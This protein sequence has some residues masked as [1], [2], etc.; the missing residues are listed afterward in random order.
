MQRFVVFCCLNMFIHWHLNSREP[1]GISCLRSPDVLQQLHSCICAVEN[2][3]VLKH[4]C[5]LFVSRYRVCARTSSPP[6]T[7]P[8]RSPG[9]RW[10]GKTICF[11][12]TTET[13]TPTGQVYYCTRISVYFLRFY[14]LNYESVGHEIIFSC[15]PN[16]THF[17][18]FILT[19][20]GLIS[21]LL[22]LMLLI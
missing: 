10:W 16:S 6:W 7:S 3:N 20:S 21:G 15:S 11:V 14:R 9:T 5:F 1:L 18:L 19:S 17:C 8:W 13:A 12:I 4:F 2:V 22:L